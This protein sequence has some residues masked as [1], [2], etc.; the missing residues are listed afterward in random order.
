MDDGY[1]FQIASEVDNPS[2]LLHDN[3]N[4]STIDIDTPYRLCSVC[5]LVLK[6]IAF[7]NSFLLV[8]CLILLQHYLVY[9]SHETI[10]NFVCNYC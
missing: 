5:E 3:L 10:I 9:A 4:W 2:E 7:I 6:L 8:E 1:G